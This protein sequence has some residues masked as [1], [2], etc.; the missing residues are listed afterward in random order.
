MILPVLV[1]VHL[2]GSIL[3]SQGGCV[4][5]VEV[6]IAH[7]C[8]GAFCGDWRAALGAIP[9]VRPQRGRSQTLE[10]EAPWSPW[11]AQA[12]WGSGVDPA[13][14]GNA[15]GGGEGA[16]VRWFN[17]DKTTL[18]VITVLFS[19][20]VLVSIGRARA[21]G[22]LF[23]R[24]I[25]GLE[26]VEE[27]V[28]RATEMGRAV[29]FVP[30]INDMDDVQTLA[31]LAILGTIARTVAA[32]DAPLLV[33]TA[34]SLVMSAARETVREAYL[35]AGRPDAYREDRVWYVTDAQFGYVA[36][37]DGLMVRQRPAAIFF[38]GAFFAESLMLAET[39]NSIGAIQVAGTAMPAQ[40]PFFVAS[41]D[42]TLIGEEL[43]AAT[44]YLT[45]EPRMVGSLKGQDMGKLL[46][47]GF[48]AAGSA[49]WTLASLTGNRSLVG[50]ASL[51]QRLFSVNP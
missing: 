9:G 47:M 42:Y 17:T 4:P 45:Q 40:L 34:R 16:R 25:A 3:P 30:G 5:G 46:A 6:A 2:H 35:A 24:R 44:A 15:A 43:F 14:S 27:A 36:A 29:L 48:I 41:C 12:A 39:G 31:G 50:V 33:P 11:T 49:A 23:I 18:L 21:R 1:A 32:Y 37:V 19:A 20:A 26:A 7:G 51:L 38:M 8:A 22:G 28:G 13:V 10:V